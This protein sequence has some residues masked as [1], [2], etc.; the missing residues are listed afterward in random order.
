MTTQLRFRQSGS[1]RLC[2]SV[3][4]ESDSIVEYNETLTVTLASTDEGVSIL[5]PTA[6]VTILDDDCM[7]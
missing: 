4:I 7:Y 5:T 2:I 3:S 1:A 6:T